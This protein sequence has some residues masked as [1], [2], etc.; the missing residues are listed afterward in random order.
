M[1]DTHFFRLQADSTGVREPPHVVGDAQAA[2]RLAIGM[3][4]S[5]L[6]GGCASTGALVPAP[7]SA[8][9]AQA[10]FYQPSSRTFESPRDLNTG[11]LEALD[12]VARAV[13]VQCE[14]GKAFIAPRS[15]DERLKSKPSTS[16]V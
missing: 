7:A 10:A 14:G 15:R 11:S 12:P 5:L 8:P 1:A 6:V 9:S 13:R 3:M 16:G 2:K 4:V